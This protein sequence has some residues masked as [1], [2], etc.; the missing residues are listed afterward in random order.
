MNAAER[1]LLRLDAHDCLVVGRRRPARVEPVVI[2]GAAANFGLTLSN[3]TSVADLQNSMVN[4]AIRM[5]GLAQAYADF[6]PTWVG[7][8]ST[9]FVDW[10]SD[11][12]RLQNRYNAALSSAQTFVTGSRFM[13]LPATEIPAPTQYD[14]LAKAMRQCY[15][16]DGCLVVKGDFD[17]LDSRLSAARGAPVPYA[18][19]VQPTRAQEGLSGAVFTATA[20]IDVVAQITGAQKAGPLPQGSTELKLLAWLAA[21]K[22]AIVVGGVAIVGGLVALQLL[23]VL[24]LPLKAAKAAAALAV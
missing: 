11:W 8:D 18:P 19:M 13:P 22:M 14:A 10:T 24:M 21:H 9:A 12:T 23:P 4:W 3:Q 1:I 7:R 16:P 15:P 6:S 20:P 17:D 2:D 5:K